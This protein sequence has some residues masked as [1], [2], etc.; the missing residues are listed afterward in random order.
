MP[1]MKHAASITPSS[2]SASE[3]CPISGRSFL[4]GVIAL[5]KK[6]RSINTFNFLRYGYYKVLVGSISSSQDFS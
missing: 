4:E 2:F 3:K 5:H 6:C 1:C